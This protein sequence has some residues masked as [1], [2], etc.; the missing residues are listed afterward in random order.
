MTLDK[1]GEYLTLAEALE[2]V[3]MTRNTLR[4]AIRSGALPAHIPRGVDPN[5]TGRGQGYRILRSDLEAWY[6][7]RKP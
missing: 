5:H 2:L 4:N 6:A 1:A 3:N 7:G